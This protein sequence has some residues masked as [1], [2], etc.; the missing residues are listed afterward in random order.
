MAEEFR[1]IN[2]YPNY[3]VLNLGNVRN[4]STGRILSPGINGN[5][6]L[7]VRLYN[8]DG[9][10]T[11]SVHKLVADCFIE[12]PEGLTDIDH[13]NRIKTDNR[14]ENMRWCSDSENQKNKTS[15]KNITYEFIEELPDDAIVVENYGNHEFTDLYYSHSLRR[16]IFNNGVHF[17][18]LHN[19]LH[20]HSYFACVIDT[21]NIKT[22]IYLNRFQRLYDL[23]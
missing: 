1:L 20:I 16:F 3:S 5:G 13:I 22:K 4:N 12:N 8:D 15:H 23:V 18:L 2:N 19:N 9:D 11:K 17:R 6:Y 21:E 10:K 7:Q 14:L